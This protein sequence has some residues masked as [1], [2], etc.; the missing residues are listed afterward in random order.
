MHPAQPASRY[1]PGFAE[2]LPGDQARLGGYQAELEGRETP[3]VVRR[4]EFGWVR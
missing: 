2:N 4:L 1:D 3:E